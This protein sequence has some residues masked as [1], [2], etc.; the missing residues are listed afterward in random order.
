MPIYKYQ[1]LTKDGAKKSGAIL[2]DDFK[3][4]YNMLRTKQHQPIEIKRVF[5]ASHEVALEDLL[6]FFLHINFQLKCGVN[7]NDAIDSFSDFHGNKTLNATLLTISNAL[8]SGESIGEAFRKSQFVF[9]EV[10]VGML[11]SAE[12]TGNTIEV[13]SNILNFLKMQMNWKNNVR[14]AIAY[15][16]FIALVALLVLILSIVFLG[17]QVAS[18]V[19]SSGDGSEIPVLTRFTLDVLPKIS[20]ILLPLL[21]LFV[22][23]LPTK[24][25]KKILECI[26]LKIPKINRLII[27]ISVWRFCKILSVALNAKVD[28]VPAFNLAMETIKLD[29]LKSELQNIRDDIMKGYKVAESFAGG[30][31]IPKEILL[32]IYVGEAG[33]DLAGSFHH[34]SEN[35][36]KEILFE[37]KSLGQV[38]SIGLTFFTGLIFVFILC[39]LF[40]PIYNYIEIVGT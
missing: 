12:D 34:I 15:P 17:P 8:K 33:N 6:A 25:G 40:Y 23:F 35:Q 11:K 27:K 31:S 38:L 16:I 3:C 7:I 26:V 36:Y 29:F 22:I 37:I 32:A 24:K 13:I 18:L 1:V 21:V 14:R 4:V 39:S 10:V 19:Q 28:F 2:A 5:W 9:D 20:E 30:S